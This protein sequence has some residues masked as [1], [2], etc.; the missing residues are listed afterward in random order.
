MDGFLVRRKDRRINM[1]PKG[2][3][4]RAWGR[5]KIKKIK[6]REA[7]GTACGGGWCGSAGC[8]TFPHSS[9]LALAAPQQSRALLYFHLENEKNLSEPPLAAY[10]FCGISCREKEKDL[11]KLHLACRR[12]PPV[13]HTHKSQG[14]MGGS[15]QQR[16]EKIAEDVR[17]ARRRRSAN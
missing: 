8:V 2:E 16:S 3:E 11:I 6:K 15:K 4:F 10:N 17:G 1:P 13:R 14:R 12:Y 9:G 7:A 5:D